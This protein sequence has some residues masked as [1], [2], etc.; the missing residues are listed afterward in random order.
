MATTSMEWIPPSYHDSDF[1]F[2]EWSGHCDS[3]FTL[4]EITENL[5]NEASSHQANEWD[6]FYRNHSGGDFFKPRKYLCQEFRKWLENSRMV[7]EVCCYDEFP[8]N[9]ANYS[10]LE[11]WLRVWMQYNSA[12][13][14]ISKYILYWIG[15]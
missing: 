6:D 12:D 5:S 13:G 9:I 15:L 3:N 4:P 14:C 10:H 7:L 2:M 1:D 11:G 8:T